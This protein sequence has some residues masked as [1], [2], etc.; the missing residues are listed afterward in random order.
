MV[1]QKICKF[2]QSMPNQEKADAVFFTAIWL[3]WSDRNAA[4]LK[5]RESGK[6]SHVMAR[7]ESEGAS[8]N[9]L[10]LSLE[11]VATNKAPN[12]PSLTF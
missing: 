6:H 8:H 7:W 3:T 9:K 2:T 10:P 11:S 12:Y 1:S 5:C 4:G